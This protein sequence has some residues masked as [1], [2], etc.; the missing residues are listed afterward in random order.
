MQSPQ[1]TRRRV[2]ALA[3][4]SNAVLCVL[5]GFAE[6]DL[7]SLPDEPCML[8]TFAVHVRPV[9]SRQLTGGILM[10]ENQIEKII[11]RALKIHRVLG[12][13]LLEHVYEAALAYELQRAGFRVRTQ[14]GLP[15]AYEE[16]KLNVGFRADAI[17]EGKVIVEIK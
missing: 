2:S 10:T 8:H 3:F 4:W 9:F 5:S 12:P 16:M 17:V 7:P 13:G 15:A 6:L 1:R 11:V 14:V